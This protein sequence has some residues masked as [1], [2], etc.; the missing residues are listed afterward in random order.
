[1]GAQELSTL[2]WRERELLE[3]L[4][5]KLEEEKL[6]LTAGKTRWLPFA[7]R[8]VEQV[9]ERLRENGIERAMEVAIVGD[10]WG[11]GDDASLRSII[12][13]AP[14]DAWRDNFT[15]HL[16][17]LSELASSIAELRDANV[18]YLRAAARVTHETLASISPEAA[19]Y[20]SRGN[21]GDWPPGGQIFD[22]RL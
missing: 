11:V 16:G 10:E 19:T 17:A 5:F 4:M 3:V 12:A 21:T 1:M 15:G 7:T 20:D 6:L 14:T 13:A 9:L 8:E 22:G 18:Q 2:L